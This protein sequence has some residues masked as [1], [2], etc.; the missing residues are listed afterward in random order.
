MRVIVEQFHVHVGQMEVQT[1]SAMKAAT[2]LVRKCKYGMV[3]GQWKVQHKKSEPATMFPQSVFFW[4][5]QR[6]KRTVPEVPR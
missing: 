5:M 4:M 1:A 6:N 3:D 2:S